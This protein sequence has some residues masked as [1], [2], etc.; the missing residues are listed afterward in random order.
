MVL[1]DDVLE[2]VE[3]VPDVS[4]PVEDGVAVVGAVVPDDVV[5]VFVDSNIA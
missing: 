5:E 3:V 2:T 1:P 4:L